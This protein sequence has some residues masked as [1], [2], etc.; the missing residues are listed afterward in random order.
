ME[1]FQICKPNDT[2]EETNL[3]RQEVVDSLDQMPKCLPS[4]YMYDKKGSKL[5]QKITKLPNYY[6]TRTEIL[7]LQKTAREIGGL[8]KRNCALI[9]FGAG[10]IEKASILLEL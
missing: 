4:H 8:Q 5:F 7:L 6:L 3:F 2:D 10:T 9:E 1:C